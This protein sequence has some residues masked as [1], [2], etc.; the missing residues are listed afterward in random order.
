MRCEATS[1]AG[2]ASA[3]DSQASGLSRLIRKIGRPVALVFRFP[4]PAFRLES[5][6]VLNH[7]AVNACCIF[8]GLVT[9]SVDPNHVHK[10]ALVVKPCR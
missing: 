2:G 4:A 10:S 3:A 1:F 6:L 7:E 5:G 8:R 9:V